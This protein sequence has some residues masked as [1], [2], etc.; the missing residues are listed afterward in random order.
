M[1]TRNKHPKFSAQWDAEMSTR[2]IQDN[3]LSWP[4]FRAGS[5]VLSC[6]ISHCLRPLHPING[7][8]ATHDSWAHGPCPTCHPLLFSSPV[9]P[10]FSLTCLRCFV[11]NLLQLPHPQKLQGAGL[12]REPP[13]K[14][15]SI[16]QD[17]LCVCLL[18]ELHTFWNL[19]SP[20]SQAQF[21][22]QSLARRS[23]WSWQASWGPYLSAEWHSM[24]LLPF[25]T[26]LPFLHLVRP[27]IA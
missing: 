21:L 6:F 11:W 23:G 7:G 3:S 18:Y 22:S 17:H 12:L 19:A 16:E 15:F 24:Q 25:W 26:S 10:L 20:F 1:Y 5:L 4:R 8:H 27:N 9:S 14:S 2:G 13:T